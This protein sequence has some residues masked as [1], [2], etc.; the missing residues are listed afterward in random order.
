MGRKFFILWVFIAAFSM[1]TQALGG[2]RVRAWVG[3]CTSDSANAIIEAFQVKVGMPGTSA[4]G[5]VVEYSLTSPRVF[6]ES[7]STRTY[8]GYTQLETIQLFRGTDTIKFGR[9]FYHTGEKDYV[10]GIFSLTTRD[11]ESGTGT[12]TYA[13]ARESSFNLVNSKD[14]YRCSVQ[15]KNPVVVELVQ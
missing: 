14:T 7:N 8:K 2:E 12:F 13:I 11:R 4:A 9:R 1:A 3:R 6:G 15:Y 5:E 10:D